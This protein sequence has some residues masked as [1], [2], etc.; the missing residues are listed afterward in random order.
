M[1]RHKIWTG[2][3]DGTQ[4]GKRIWCGLAEVDGFVEKQDL[5][6]VWVDGRDKV[7]GRQNFWSSWKKRFRGKEGERPVLE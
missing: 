1:I 5:C 3:A 6:P 4:R 2:S 7:P